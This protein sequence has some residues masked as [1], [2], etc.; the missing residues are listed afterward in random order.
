MN[1]V[2]ECVSRGGERA[3]VC[4]RLVSGG[5]RSPDLPRALK[6]KVPQREV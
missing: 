1:K 2:S 5:S 6:V 3:R 4:H